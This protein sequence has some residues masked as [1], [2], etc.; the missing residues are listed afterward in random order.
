MTI[1]S[2][3]FDSPMPAIG[4]AMNVDAISRI[5]LDRGKVLPVPPADVLVHSEDGFEMEALAYISELTGSG[6]RC[7]NSVFESRDCA[8]EYAACKESARVDFVGRQVE[9]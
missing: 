3:C 1:C 2:H 7:E 5:L 4:F 8:L 6:L 9:R